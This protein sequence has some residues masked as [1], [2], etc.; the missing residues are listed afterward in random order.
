MSALN[1]MKAMMRMG[2]EFIPYINGL[3][4][5]NRGGNRKGFPFEILMALHSLSEQHYDAYGHLYIKDDLWTQ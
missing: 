5:D 4:H 2:R 1:V 3:L